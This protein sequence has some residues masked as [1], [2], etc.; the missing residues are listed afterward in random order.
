[1]MYPILIKVRYEALPTLLRSR[2]LWLHILFSVFVNWIVAPLVMTALAW[3]FLPDRAA[4]R[5][6]L[7]LVGVARCIAMV[8][9][10]TDLARGDGDY[11][12]ILVA[13]NSLLQL[14]LFA[15]FTVFYV[16]IV[17][18]SEATIDVD[19]SLVARSVGVFLGIPLAAAIT[20][21]F[22]VLHIVCRG[23][24]DRWH[25]GFVR[26]VAPWSLL[27]L[28]FTI[29]ILFAQQGANVVHQIA[30]VARVAAPLVVYFVAVFAAT[31][32]ACRRWGRWSYQITVTQ[33]LTAASNN[34]ELAIA[35]AVAVFG[36][37]SEQALAAT[38]G[39]L[40]EVPV[41]L[42]LVEV[43]KWM[44]RRWEWQPTPDA[45]AGASGGRGERTK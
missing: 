26:W 25:R 42:A 23:D 22:L 32:T 17:A 12:A 27:G 29:L 14:V 34:F 2:Q 11:C 10:W 9:V 24:L 39:P 45:E 8:L 44:G 20:T 4:L 30:A 31:V 33:S 13:V 38:V 7:I 5:E 40:V 41:L 21:R 15:P 19:Y 28:L 3:A 37:Q 43:V 35:V 18:R 1:M 16:G 36:P 6:G